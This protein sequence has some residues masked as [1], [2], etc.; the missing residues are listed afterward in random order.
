MKKLILSLLAVS[1]ASVG[2][3][4]DSKLSMSADLTWT[5]E[6][7]FRGFRLANGSFQPSLEVGYANAYV[8][9]WANQALDDADTDE[10]DL[11]AGY[12][13]VVEGD[14]SVDL[15]VTRYT[16][17]V[18]NDP[19]PAA[20]APAIS[21]RKGSADTT[22]AYIGLT[23]GNFAG[24]TPSVY[25][26]HDF[27]LETYTYQASVGYSI[28]LSTLGTSLDWSASLGYVTN[29]GQDFIFANGFSGKTSF[30]DFYY[31][32]VGVNVP[33][34]LA[35]NATLTGG[36][37]YAASESGNELANNRDDGTIYYTLGVTLGF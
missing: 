15:G 27:D 32:S 18:P 4:Q 21:S 20:P 3:A 23:G 13:F 2:F 22:E 11:Y 1:T 33:Y 31:Y 37:N 16:Y 5:S 28:P 29:V 17:D 14:W 8:G 30:R 34:K 12:K 25:V 24:F 6:Y 35:E 36:V 7:V 26:Y 19:Q 10:I 9:A